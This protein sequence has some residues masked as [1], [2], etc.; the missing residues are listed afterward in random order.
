MTYRAVSLFSGCG[1]MDVGVRQAGFRTVVASELNKHAC[2]TFRKNHT[3]VDLVEGD[4][5]EKMD[6][7]CKYDD[8]DLVFGGPPC[9]GFSVAGKMSPNDLRSKLVFSFCSVV[10]RVKPH[11]FVLEN[12][13]ALGLLAKFEG[14]RS[15]LTRRMGAA[16]YVTNFFILNSRD[17]GVPQNRE[18]VFFIGSKVRRT[19]VRIGCIEQHKSEALTLREAIFHLGPAGSQGNPNV[20]KAKITL[21]ANPVMRRSPYAGML[22]NGQGRPLN[23]DAWSSTLPASMG[24]NRTPIIDEDHLYYNKPSWVEDYHAKLVKGDTQSVFTEAPKRLRRMTVDEAAI[25]QTFPSDY[26][27]EGPQSSIFSQIGNA[28]PCKLAAAVFSAVRKNLDKDDSI[29]L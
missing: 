18:R 3:N 1:G 20:T 4:I 6:D 13:K 26:I 29:S 12:V 10:E 2:S 7:I 22:F 14:V 19:P 25:I 15:E 11:A 28:V 5:D 27:F 17:Y 9:Q 23:P 8:I 16:G 21:A 24:G